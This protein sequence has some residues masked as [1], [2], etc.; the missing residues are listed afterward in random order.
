MQTP[1][2]AGFFQTMELDITKWIRF[3][4]NEELLEFFSAEDDSEMA[5]FALEKRK[6]GLWKWFAGNRE[7]A[8]GVLSFYSFKRTRSNWTLNGILGI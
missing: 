1:N 5:A 4:S 6:T 7:N 8:R 2:Y 3:N